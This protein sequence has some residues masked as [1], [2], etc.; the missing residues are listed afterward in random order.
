MATYNR[1]YLRLWLVF[2]VCGA[3]QPAFAAH[4]EPHVS[5][6]RQVDPVRNGLQSQMLSFANIALWIASAV[7]DCLDAW[8]VHPNS[9]CAVTSLFDHMLRA[10]DGQRTARMH[11]RFSLSINRR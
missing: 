9:S 4:R 2:V 3:A 8:L 6:M 7:R 11:I 1:W 10:L 5:D